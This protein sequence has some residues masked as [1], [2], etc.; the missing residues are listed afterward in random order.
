MKSFHEEYPTIEE[1]EAYWAE[2]REKEQEWNFKEGLDYPHKF[3]KEYPKEGVDIE[4]YY[5]DQAPRR[6][7]LRFMGGPSISSCFLPHGIKQMDSWMGRQISGE[8]KFTKKEL[9]KMIKHNFHLHNVIKTNL[10][11]NLKNK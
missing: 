6:V 5:Y 1:K 10:L 8:S 11:D 3:K 2:Q 7:D 4:D 9:K